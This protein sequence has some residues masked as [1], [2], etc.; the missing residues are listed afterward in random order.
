[1]TPPARTQLLTL[2][3]S[4]LLTLMPATALADA[5]EVRPTQVARHEL[6]LSLS[7]T[8]LL[9]GIAGSFAL[10]A[11]ALDDRVA[12]LPRALAE[13]PELQE[14]AVSA[15]RLAWGFGSAA[16]LVALTSVLIWIYQPALPDQPATISPVVSA[17]QLGVNYH[18]RF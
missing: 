1:M 6:W 12:L 2:T 17:G 16:S 14:D 9:G 13:R 11:A 15:R 10:K 18:A 7:A 3:V 8:F 5:P 4:A